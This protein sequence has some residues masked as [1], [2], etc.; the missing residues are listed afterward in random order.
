MAEESK[1]APIYVTR[2]SLP[3]LE[4]FI[5]SLREIWNSKILTNGGPFHEKFEQKLC[6]YLA[7]K[8]IALF[9][10]ATIGLVTALQALRITG[11]VITTPYSFVATA[12]SLLWNGIKPVFVDIDPHTLNLDP[13][14][15]EAAITPQTTAIMPVHCYGHPCDVDAIQAIADTYGLK[16]IYDAAHAF[17]VQCHCGSVLTHGDLSVLSFHATKV[18]TT[19]EGGAIVC[20]DEK[21]RQRINFLKNFGFADEVTVVAPGINGKM[22]EFNAALGLLQLKGVDAALAERRAIDERYRAGL[23]DVAGIR[24]LQSA[25]EI[26]SNYAYF[27]ILVQPDYPLARDE[28]FQKLRE[29]DI[30][31]RRYFY[32]LISDFPMYR[33]LPSAAHSNLP[34]ARK[35]AAQVLCLPIYPGLPHEQ[36]DRV[37]ELLRV[38][39]YLSGKSGAKLRAL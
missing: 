7:V 22:S 28:L 24:C 25:G 12:H 16:V 39:T 20:P 9:T 21:S 36:V 32:P 23:A 37:L 11:E 3:D 5:P 17:G 35:M 2:P 1:P 8:Q 27:P 34:I 38:G 6:E 29:K 26:R 13:S 33:S 31:V 19:F 4:E 30:F 15:I 18:F 10:N 14:K